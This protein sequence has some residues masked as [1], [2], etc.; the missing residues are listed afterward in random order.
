MA[1]RGAYTIF[2]ARPITILNSP[3]INNLVYSFCKIYEKTSNG[4]LAITRQR[5]VPT[6]KVK[7][8]LGVT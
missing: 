8:A 2:C 3:G 7:L 6:V 1:S 5:V 4:S